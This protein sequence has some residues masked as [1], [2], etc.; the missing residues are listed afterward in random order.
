MKIKHGLLK[1]TLKTSK[2]LSLVMLLL[3]PQTGLLGKGSSEPLYQLQ[4][5]TVSLPQLSPKYQ[6]HL[7]EIEE[8][9]FMQKQKL[10]DEMILSQH[11][12][13]LAKK[14]KK[15]VAE[16]LKTLYKEP[17]VG[18]D[19]AKKWFNDN[20]HILG[21]R[22]FDSIKNEIVMMLK[23]KEKQ[24]A[25][26]ALLE[27]LKQDGKFK[28]MM[29][30]PEAPV[31]NIQ[32][33][34]FHRKGEKK[35]PIKIVEFADY[36]CPHCRTAAMNLKKIVSQYPNK[37]E[38]IFIDFPIN[39]SGISR[40]VAVGAVCAGEQNRFWEYHYLA[41]EKQSELKH[42]SPTLFAKE[43]KLDTKK[44]SACLTMKSTEQ[45]VDAGLKEGERIGVTGTPAIYING[46]KQP[47][48]EERLLAEIKRLL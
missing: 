16:V 37:I 46:K 42:E 15:T 9:V 36:Q 39:R 34:G 11:V 33:E 18:I 8:Q 28:N 31:I 25:Q 32:L 12:E 4:G 19:E 45:K 30:R 1:K 20:Q 27:K 43:L 35:A 23:G 24:K 17:N 14:G 29:A 22:T 2:N 26:R 7:Y 6:Q 3:I 21:G 48:N 13:G 44:F 47:N 38:F 41:F 10:I 40:K 5:K